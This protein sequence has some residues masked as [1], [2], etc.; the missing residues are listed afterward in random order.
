M[1]WYKKAIKEE[2]WGV[3]QGHDYDPAADY[4][5]IQKTNQE[6]QR[7]VNDA[8][9]NYRKELLPQL[10]IFR[11]VRVNFVRGGTLGGKFG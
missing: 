4:Q 10:K 1:S 3:E 8:L 11:D 6:A 7:I 5:V 2:P 9:N